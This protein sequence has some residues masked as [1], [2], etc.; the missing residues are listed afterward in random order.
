MIVGL[1]DSF[2]I[3]HSLLD[4][5]IFRRTIRWTTMDQKKRQKRV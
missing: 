3:C 2:D 5:P 4:L 1:G